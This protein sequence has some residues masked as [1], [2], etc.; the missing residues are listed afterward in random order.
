MKFA[1]DSSALTDAVVWASK[2]VNP[3]HATPILT[4]LMLTA[5][6]GELTISGF[7]H[8]TSHTITIAADTEENG[9]AL[10]PAAMLTNIL[11]AMPSNRPMTVEVTDK[12][13]LRC[14]KSRFSTPVMDITQYPTLP[15][16]PGLWGN[17]AGDA[18]VSAVEKVEH[19][20]A[21]NENIDVLFGIRVEPADDG[22][23]SFL[24][25]DRYRMA[26][27]DT[28]WNPAIEEPEGFLIKASTLSNVAKGVVGEL[29]ILL[30]GNI[31]GFVSGNKVTTSALMAGQ[32]PNVR[33]MFSKGEK[34]AVQVISADLLAAVNR[35]SVVIEGTN[36]VRLAINQ[37]E[38][39]VDAGSGDSSTGEEYVDANSYIEGITAGFNPQY[40]ADALRTIRTETVSIEFT[41]IEGTPDPRKPVTIREVVDGSALDDTAV[42]LMPQRLN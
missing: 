34:E 2:A 37:G 42:L 19:A 10:V 15:N 26:Y 9:K 33:P 30:S 3:R 36:P 39:A 41:A 5:D 16:V 7:D 8:T 14:G 35:A 21:K 13:H 22:M 24:A 31:V 4:G 1:I 25:T 23:L 29:K 18:F 11:K 40:L 38:I 20:A 12:A 32:Y 27:A 17:I 6:N 28:E